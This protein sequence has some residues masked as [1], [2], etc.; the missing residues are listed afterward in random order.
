MSDHLPSF[1]ADI[2]RR[3]DAALMFARGD[4]TVV[5]VDVGFVYDQRGRMTGTVDVRV[6][7]RTSKSIGPVAVGAATTEPSRG[8]MNVSHSGT[9][10]PGV[11]IANP[12]CTFGTLGLIV[13]DATTRRP[14]IM[15]SSHVLGYPGT[16]PGERVDL[17]PAGTAKPRPIATFSRAVNDMT[18]DAAVA[19]PIPGVEID[20]VEI[21]G[22][23]VARA[24][25]P[26][27]GDVVEKVGAATGRTCGV[28]DGVGRYFM[29]SGGH[30]MLGFRIVRGTPNGT[31]DLALPGDS[32]AVWYRQGDRAGVGLHVGGDQSVTD[33]SLQPAIACYLPLV[34]NTLAVSLTHSS[35]PTPNDPPRRS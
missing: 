18:G 14:L 17:I 29:A 23:G 27:L 33:E 34:L 21:D 7:R 13:F 30:G 25:M 12:R 2:E 3:Y 8:A 26:Q 11:R 24:A 5:G 1:D 35:P 10:G 20:G 6:H 15:S 31:R 19:E 4:R 28:V 9:I 16:S 32:G 22:V